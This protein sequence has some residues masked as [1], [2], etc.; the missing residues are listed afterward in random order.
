MS[1]ST[2]DRISV[3]LCAFA[4]AC[5]VLSWSGCSASAAMR[6][7]IDA[8]NA[9]VAVLSALR[10]QHEAK[11][12]AEYLR[13]SSSCPA[14]SGEARRACVVASGQSALAALAPEHTRLLELELLEH[15]V[16]SALQAAAKCNKDAACEAA[17]LA[18]A[19]GPAARLK[20]ALT[21][22]QP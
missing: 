17:A 20:D 2:V 12:I 3:G 22:G 11:L 8:N 1:T 7:A 4:W 14:E 6:T 19:A 15:T 9:S 16:A 18:Q 10:E 21:G 5:I 13:R